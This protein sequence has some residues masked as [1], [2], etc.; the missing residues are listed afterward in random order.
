MRRRRSPFVLVTVVLAIATV[1]AAAS[2]APVIYRGSAAYDPSQK[3]ELTLDKGRITDYRVN[4]KLRCPDGS[5]PDV[6]ASA[7]DTPGG[8]TPVAVSNH[9]FEIDRGRKEDPT[10]FI[11]SLRGALSATEAQ[12]DVYLTV[13]QH[14]GLDAPMCTEEFQWQAVPTAAT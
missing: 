6:V 11:A 13:G 7:N 14:P 1:P 10:V 5:R 2:A 8:Y 3:I 4:A 9:R 12:G